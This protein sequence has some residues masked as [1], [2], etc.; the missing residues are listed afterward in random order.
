MADE[1]SNDA[2]VQSGH[3]ATMPLCHYANVLLCHRA[4]LLRAVRSS[5]NVIYTVQELPQ[6]YF[7]GCT[8]VT[9]SRLKQYQTQGAANK[10][11]VCRLTATWRMGVH[12]MARSQPLVFIHEMEQMLRAAAGKSWSW[13][14]ADI[15]DPE[16]AIPSTMFVSE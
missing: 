2:T 5:S 11:G 16:S 14:L 7:Q 13:D 4:V 15:P 8:Y 10:H 3:Y 1:C 6:A 12:V 9:P